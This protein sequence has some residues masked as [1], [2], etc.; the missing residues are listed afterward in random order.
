MLN[1]GEI[2]IHE[3]NYSATKNI[4]LEDY[5]GIKWKHEYVCVYISCKHIHNHIL[6][7]PQRNILAVLEIWLSRQDSSLSK[8]DNLSLDLQKPCQSQTQWHVSR[9][10]WQD[11][12]CTQENPQGQQI[13]STPHSSKETACLKARYQ[14]RT[15]TQ[16]SRL[17]YTDTHGH[18]SCWQN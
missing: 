9:I 12:R 16:A 7:I 18:L 8:H 3:C 2:K 14:V 6:K 4:S 13:Q 15:G 1:D 5:Y 10:L 17:T 11:G